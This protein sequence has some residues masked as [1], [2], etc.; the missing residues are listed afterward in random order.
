MRKKPSLKVVE[1]KS[2]IRIIKSF[3]DDFGN[4]LKRQTEFIK[5]HG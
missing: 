5:K 3:Y 4:V 1:L 2:G